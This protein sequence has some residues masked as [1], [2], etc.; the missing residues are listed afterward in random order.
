MFVF[1]G[2][3]MELLKGLAR[4]RTDL[5]KTSESLTR[6]LCSNWDLQQLAY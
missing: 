2:T 1:V 4:S 5:V 3:Y 6:H